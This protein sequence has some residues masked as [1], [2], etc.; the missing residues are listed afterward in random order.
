L[1]L[2]ISVCLHSNFSCGLRKTSFFSA[3]V[4]FGR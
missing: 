4:W 1:P 3:R 2:I